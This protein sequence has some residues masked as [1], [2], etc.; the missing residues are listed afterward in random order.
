MEDTYM[1]N[2]LEVVRSHMAS[3]CTNKSSD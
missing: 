1:R 3:S 2:E